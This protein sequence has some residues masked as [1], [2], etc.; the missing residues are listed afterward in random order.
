M[1]CNST[2]DDLQTRRENCAV[3]T[4]MSNSK[5]N[6]HGRWLDV[7]CSEKHPFVCRLWHNFNNRYVNVNISRIINNRG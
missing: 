4:V 5:L 2:I 7:D 6:G 3:M 1:I